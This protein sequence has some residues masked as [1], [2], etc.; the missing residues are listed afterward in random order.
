MSSLN[1]FDQEL[2][3]NQDDLHIALMKGNAGDFG[4]FSSLTDRNNLKEKKDHP[5]IDILQSSTQT[6]LFCQGSFK[7]T[8]TY[9]SEWSN[10]DIDIA[11]AEMSS[12]RAQP[13]DEIW[14]SKNFSKQINYSENNIVF[15]ANNFSNVTF[16]DWTTPGA[17][18]SLKVDN[19]RIDMT[20]DNTRFLCATYL[21]NSF[22][23]YRTSINS[24]APNELLTIQKSTIASYV[25]FT[26]P[27]VKD[28]LELVAYQV[29][30]MKSNTL[31]V[32][33]QSN[34]N[35]LVYKWDK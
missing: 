12:T 13:S 15:T 11:V 3:L 34:N 33:N 18:W 2:L 8:E 31:N 30:K 9:S 10:N 29:Y 28:G 23:H 14:Y 32:E 1:T 26:G 6:T 17:K 21:N 19:I 24:I 4:K 35:V 16:D 7:I 5:T 27:V 22:K 25:I 20:E